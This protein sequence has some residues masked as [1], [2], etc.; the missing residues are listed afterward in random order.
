MLRRFCGFAFAYMLLNGIAGSAS[1]ANE[2]SDYLSCIQNAVGRLDDKVSPAD[3]VARG[4]LSACDSSL[5]RYVEHSYS[6][7][8]KRQFA[9]D[10]IRESALEKAIEIVLTSRANISKP[11]RDSGNS[12]P[13]TLGLGSDFKGSQAAGFHESASS[14]PGRF[15]EAEQPDGSKISL[16][17]SD[18]PGFSGKV[19]NISQS[20]ALKTKRECVS[21]YNKLIRNNRGMEI[22]PQPDSIGQSSFDLQDVQA[23][24]S[25][26]SEVQDIT[27]MAAC[28]RY[29]QGYVAEIRFGYRKVSA[30]Q[31]AKDWAKTV[32]SATEN[33]H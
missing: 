10:A 22:K 24:S 29:D 8:I 30:E 16:I 5:Q 32:N 26:S 6:E 14:T 18:L 3:V 17:I 21:T 15:Y 13:E 12:Q 4:A 9:R 33:K 1:D 2:A 23:F 7:T 27:G 28:S 31:Y 11:S 20:Y 19:I 25:I